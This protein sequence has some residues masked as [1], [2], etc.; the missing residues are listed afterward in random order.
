MIGGNAN[1]NGTA[2]SSGT[3]R[4]N[5]GGSG[6]QAYSGSSSSSSSNASTKATQANTKA[7][8]D[9]TKKTENLKD[10]IDTLVTTIKFYLWLYIE[11]YIENLSFCWKTLR[12]LYT[13][14]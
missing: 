7:V 12:A 6:S 8:E 4:F 3:G 1:V 11:R 2:Y 5:A 9:N 14:T 10:W 13:T